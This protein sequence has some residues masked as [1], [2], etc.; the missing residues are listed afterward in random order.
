MLGGWQASRGRVLGRRERPKG[1]RAEGRWSSH[2]KEPCSTRRESQA[3]S[4]AQGLLCQAA[5]REGATRERAEREAPQT[6]RPRTGGRLDRRSA[7]G[8]AVSATGRPPIASR[9]PKRRSGAS[10]GG[11]GR[12]LASSSGADTKQPCGRARSAGCWFL[13]R[14]C[15]ASA[16][17]QWLR[18]GARA[19][20]SSVELTLPGGPQ[21]G[22][23]FERAQGGGARTRRTR[24][25]LVGAGRGE[26]RAGSLEK[27]T[28]R[29][30]GRE[31]WRCAI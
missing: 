11:S 14:L 21:L 23:L 28:Q 6:P 26:V 8:R 3:P 13:C 16:A 12:S 24:L 30:S 4:K 15:L 20:T 1:G 9:S 2:L 7:D 19:I 5:W 27:R 31:T 18:S 10:G 25:K 17:L 22:S 29:W